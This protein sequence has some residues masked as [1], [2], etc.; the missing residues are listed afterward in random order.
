MADATDYMAKKWEERARPTTYK[1]TDCYK[2]TDWKEAIPAE[3]EETMTFVASGISFTYPRKLI[4]DQLREQWFVQEGWDEWRCQA[5]GEYLFGN[6]LFMFEEGE[7]LNLAYKGQ[8][9]GHPRSPPTTEHKD[10][11][12]PVKWMREANDRAAKSHCLVTIQLEKEGAV[13]VAQ[14]GDDYT[15]HIVTWEALQSG[16]NNPL[17]EAIEAAERH[18]STLLRL[19]EIACQPTSDGASATPQTKPT[20]KKGRAKRAKREQ[21]K[22]ANAND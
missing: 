17:I 4:E 8:H 3:G 20:A 6:V 10:G 2:A 19:K 9:I 5:T 7:Y 11:H 18:L 16:I 12:F 1:A 21:R 14:E 15:T 13:V 22:N